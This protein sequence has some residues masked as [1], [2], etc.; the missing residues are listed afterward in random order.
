MCVLYSRVTL[1]ALQVT[2]IASARCEYRAVL[3]YKLLHLQFKGGSQ[4]DAH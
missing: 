2:E 1:D 3:V 4:E